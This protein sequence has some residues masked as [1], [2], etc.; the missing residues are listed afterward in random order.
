M[1]KIVAS[2]VALLLSV[3]CFAGCD[4]DNSPDRAYVKIG[5]VWKEV[6]IKSTCEHCGGIW[7]LELTD[8]TIM[9][10]D[11]VNCILYKGTLSIKK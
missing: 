4:I 5:D 9:F 7:H 2:I 11:A 1:K 6:E 3:T 10:V 8:G